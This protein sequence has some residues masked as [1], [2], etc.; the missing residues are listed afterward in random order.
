MNKRNFKK[1]FPIFIL[2]IIVGLFLIPLLRPLIVD[3]LKAIFG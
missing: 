3:W 1:M 2:G